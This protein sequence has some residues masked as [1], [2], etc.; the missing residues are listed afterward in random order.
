MSFIKT[1]FQAVLNGY[2]QRPKYQ[3]LLIIVTAIYFTF[4]AILGLLVPYIV[5]KQVPEQLSSLLQRPVTLENVKVNP[6]TL[7][8]AIDKFEL[9]ETDS[10]PFVGFSQLNFEYQFW[11]SV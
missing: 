1:S 6:F 11:D 3:R 2:R 8:V 7:E 4:T 5:V 9:Q 10:K